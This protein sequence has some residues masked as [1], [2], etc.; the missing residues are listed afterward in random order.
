ML[1]PQKALRSGPRTSVAE[2]PDSN[3]KF[4]RSEGGISGENYAVIAQDDEGTSRKR[5]GDQILD[6]MDRKST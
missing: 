2:S 3:W 1:L 4:P 5:F 6:T